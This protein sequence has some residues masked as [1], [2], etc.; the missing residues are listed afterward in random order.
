MCFSDASGTVDY[1]LR[2]FN[3]NSFLQVEF[4]EVFQ[5]PFQSRL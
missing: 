4:F 1:F 2:M 5:N 3:L